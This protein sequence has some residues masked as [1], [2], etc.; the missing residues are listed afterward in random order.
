MSADNG[1]VIQVDDNGKY[2][3]QMYFASSDEYPDPN[4]EGV[5]KFKTLEAAV[6]RYYE[7]ASQEDMVIEYGLSLNLS[8]EKE[9]RMQTKKYARKAF[10][11][12]AIQ[13]TAENMEEVAQ[14]AEGEIQQDPEQSGTG[15]VN[16]IFIN[17]ERPL[18]DR[19]T[20][21]YMGDWVLSAGRGFKVYTNKAFL[22]SFEVVEDTKN[23]FD[24]VTV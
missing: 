2:V 19:Q 18:N 1:Y 7:I 5:E 22:S 21:A 16:Y 4:A 9:N 3:L 24:G 23:V 15:P 6:R 8:N 13:V 10:F 14:W 11:V 20:K 17:V 12:E